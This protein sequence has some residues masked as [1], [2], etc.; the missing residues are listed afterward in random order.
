M[1][2][3]GESRLIMKIGGKNGPPVPIVM[4]NGD[5]KTVYG[6]NLGAWVGLPVMTDDFESIAAKVSLNAHLKL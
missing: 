6:P 2:R 1:S 4:G 3:K 5:P